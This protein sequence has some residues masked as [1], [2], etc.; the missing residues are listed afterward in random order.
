MFT[1]FV[2]M[3]VGIGVLMID[4]FVMGYFNRQHCGKENQLSMTKG[5]LGE[6]HEEHVGHGDTHAGHGQDGGV[7]Y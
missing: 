7:K 1:G 6:Q 3:V 5:D 2:V 4:S